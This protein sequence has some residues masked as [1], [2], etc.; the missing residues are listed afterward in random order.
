MQVC[1][2]GC[3]VERVWP[4]WPVPEAVFLWG[5]LVDAVTV[6]W[7]CCFVGA[8][9]HA[10]VCVPLTSIWHVLRGAAASSSVLWDDLPPLTW[11][12]GALGCLLH[13]YLGMVWPV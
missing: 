1:L 13:P 5:L 12:A 8:L 11:P 6:C 9:R 3:V 7:F 4:C 2:L 10:H